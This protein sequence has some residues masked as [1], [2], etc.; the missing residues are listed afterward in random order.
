[1]APDGQA[2][3]L[4]RFTPAKMYRQA[5]VKMQR[6]CFTNSPA[7]CS[8]RANFSSCSASKS[9]SCGAGSSAGGVRFGCGGFG[10]QSLYGIGGCKKITTGSRCGGGIRDSRG[11]GLVWLP[12][13]PCFPVCPPGG[14][15][16]VT[17]NQNLLLPLNLE[18]D[19]NIPRIRKEEGEQIKML[20]NKFACFIDK[21]RFLEQQNKVLE[22]KWA[23]LQEQC[24]RTVRKNMNHLFECYISN[25][26]RQLNSLE[27][28]R[29]R[30]LGELEKTQ[31]LVEDFKNRYEDELNKRTNAENEFVI[32]KKDVDTACI[33]KTELQAKVDSLLDEINFLKCLYEQ[34]IQQFREQISDTCVILSMDNNRNLDLHCIIAEVKARFEEIAN[35]S[36]MEIECWYQCKLEELRRAAGKHGDQLCNTKQEISEIRRCINKLRSEIENVKK[37]CANLQAKMADAEDRGELLLKDA[38]QK[39]AELDDALHR[40]KQDMAQQLRDYHE[41]MNVKLGLDIEIAT[42]RKLLEGEECRL[43]SDAVN[44]SVVSSNVSR[45]GIGICGAVCGGGSSIFPGRGSIPALGGGCAALDRDP[46]VG[47]SKREVG[48]RVSIA[49][50][51]CSS[52][53]FVCSSQ[54]HYKC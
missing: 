10:S 9:V 53:D 44:V 46:C 28:I 43:G 42:Y 12:C 15:H 25:M 13:G 19:P 23:L 18:I 35:R 51:S 17:I 54:K 20:N 6:K 30:Q 37:Q 27:D 31:N 11:S 32:I 52:V 2:S 5:S 39:L 7:I 4:F 49:G 38:R 21:V 26:R 40:A 3:P 24:Q 34:E 14:I 41:L 16:E 22:T 29:G 45:G 48:G 1:M 50:S 36:R 33:I 8:S 47:G